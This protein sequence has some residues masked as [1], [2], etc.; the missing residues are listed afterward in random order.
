MNREGKNAGDYPKKPGVFWRLILKLVKTSDRT[1]PWYRWPLRLGV[2]VLAVRRAALR[3]FN[4]IPV[5]KSQ[6]YHA[7]LSEKERKR[8]RRQNEENRDMYRDNEGKGN[9]VLSEDIGALG[10]YFGRNTAPVPYDQRLHDPNSPPVELVAERLLMRKVVEDASDSASASSPGREVFKP[11]GMQFNIMAAAWIQAMIHDWMNHEKNLELKK[12][13]NDGQGGDFKFHPTA[14]D[15][16]N[17]GS[18]NVR[19][20]WWDASFVYGQTEQQVKQGRTGSGGKMKEG[21]GNRLAVDDDGLFVVGDQENSW[22]G[23]ALLQELFIKEHNAVCDL[24]AEKHPGLSD[25]ELFHKA[26][27]VVAAIVAKIHTM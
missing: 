2:L 26:R 13:L 1:F 11:A 20:A 5:G 7:K 27:L 25:D 16:D 6:V 8:I 9:D 17:G 14:I 4:L 19:T 15:R 12:S 22:V 18:K 24:I 21:E 10:S 23:I 3:K